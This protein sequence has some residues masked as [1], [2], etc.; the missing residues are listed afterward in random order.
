MTTPT[1]VEATKQT[2][3][4]GVLSRLEEQIRLRVRLRAYELYEQRGRRGAHALDDWLQAETELA[5]DMVGAALNELS[6]GGAEAEAQRL[7]ILWD[8]LQQK[9]QP[10]ISQNSV[11]PTKSR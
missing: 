11:C 5:N 8:K 10:G 7:A 1:P 2:D 9:L 4:T 3:L 6:R